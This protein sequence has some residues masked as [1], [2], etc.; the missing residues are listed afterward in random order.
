M[1]KETMLRLE[2][3]VLYWSPQAAQK[4]LWLL[5]TVPTEVGYHGIAHPDHPLLVMDILVP[6][7][8]CTSAHFDFAD[9][10]GEQVLDYAQEH[11]INADR[12]FPIVGHTH[13]SG[14]TGPS[15]TDENELMGQIR[16]LN[17]GVMYIQEKGKGI[18]YC[19]LTWNPDSG[20]SVDVEIKSALTWGY[21]RDI[22]TPV[23]WQAEVDENVAGTTAVVIGKG[24]YGDGYNRVNGFQGQSPLSK[25]GSKAASASNSGGTWNGGYQ[26]EKYH[27]GKGDYGGTGKWSNIGHKILYAR[28]VEFWCSRNFRSPHNPSEAIVNAT[29]EEKPYPQSSFEWRKFYSSLSVA[30][31]IDVDELVLKRYRDQNG[32]EMLTM[33]ALPEWDSLLYEV[34]AHEELTDK[35]ERYGGVMG[36]F[37]FNMFPEGNAAAHVVA[38]MP[39]SWKHDLTEKYKAWDKVREGEITTVQAEIDKY[40]E[41]QSLQYNKEGVLTLYMSLNENEAHQE[42]LQLAREDVA[43]DEDLAATIAQWDSLPNDYSDAPGDDTVIEPTDE[44]L[45]IIK[46]TE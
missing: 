13:P 21:G 26:Q 17:W 11:G 10:A 46:A 30:A 16:A 28:S 29:V 12:I 19:R 1:S 34:L 23:E 15:G 7:Q 20:P 27:Y 6:K 39:G 5:E 42:E 32:N 35:G 44:D 8:E 37:V 38:G 41:F 25:G 14:V 24:S 2:K 3:N 43:T 36:V 45:I 31:Q 33:S 4:R 22:G 9:T 18:E 40:D